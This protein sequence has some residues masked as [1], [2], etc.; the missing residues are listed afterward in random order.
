MENYKESRPWG[1]FEN[2]ADEEYCKVKKIVVSPGGRLSLQSHQ[3][4]DEHWILVKGEATVTCLPNYE[5]AILRCGCHVYIPRGS[6]HRL[7][8]RTKKEL[9]LVEVQVGLSFEESDIIRYEDI[10]NRT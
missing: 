2:L 6:K 7:E 5:D 4:R 10:Y 9:V 1:D 3:F 8:N